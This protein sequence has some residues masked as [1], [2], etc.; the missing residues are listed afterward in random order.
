MEQTQLLEWEGEDDPGDPSNG[1]GDSGEPP[2]PVGRLHLLSNKYGPEKDFWIYPGE[3]VVGRLESCQ[4]CLPAPS[5]SKSHAVI[6]VP[7]PDGPH[8]LYDKGSLNRTR[9]QRLV[10][11]PEVRYS[12]Q[13]G[14]ALLFGDVRCQYFILPLGGAS[15]S[16]DESTEVP[17]TQARPDA[18]ALAIE[19]TPA[20]GR[21]TGSEGVLVHDSDKEE[22]G[23]D[24]MN[25][26]GKRNGSDPAVHDAS[27]GSFKV[28]SSMF[29]SPSVA[30]VPESDEENE[31]ASVRELPYPSVRLCFE[32]QEAEPGTLENGGVTPLNHKTHGVEPGDTEVTAK[33]QP[34]LEERMATTQESDPLIE[35][36]HL[37]SD[38]DVE[39]EEGTGGTSDL[40]TSRCLPETNKAPDVG[41]DT[42]VDEPVTGN[43]DN[44]KNHPRTIDVGSDTDVEET[45]EDPNVPQTHEPA[46]NGED[47][48]DA[49]EGTEK[50][51][52]VG[53]FEPGPQKEGGSKDIR[54][55]KEDS[56]VTTPQGHQLGED[57]DTDVE[58]DVGNSDGKAQK[59]LAKGD[60]DTD[61]DDASLKTKSPD[62]SQK[63]HEAGQDSDSDTVVDEE[64]SAGGALR[65]PAAVQDG[66]GDTDEEMSDLVL[67]HSDIAGTQSSHPVGG[68][69][70]DA[71]VE[72]TPLKGVVLLDKSYSG[73]GHKGTAVEAENPSVQLKGNYESTSGQLQSLVGNKPLENTV[74]VKDTA[75]SSQKPGLPIVS[76]DSDTDLEEEVENP[77]VGPKEGPQVAGVGPGEGSFLENS[78]AGPPESPV[79]GEAGDSDTDVEGNSPSRKELVAQGSH[80]DVE[81]AAVPSPGKPQEEQATQL[82]VP[83][84]ARMADGESAAP[85]TEVRVCQEPRKGDE[86]TATEGSEVPPADDDSDT[87]DDPDVA[88]QATQ[89]FLPPE[90]SSP[91]PGKAHRM[92]VADSSSCLEE[93]ATQPFIFQSPSL[94]TKVP[95][96]KACSSLLKE[97]NGDPYA[98]MLEAT[99]SFCQEPEPFSEE[100]TQAFAAPEEEDT[101]LVSRNPCEESRGDPL[102]Q[103]TT[104]ALPA[105]TARGQQAAG[106]SATTP[107]PSTLGSP[108][109]ELVSRTAT[110]V[111]VETPEKE[112]AETSRSRQIPSGPSGEPSMAL[113]E[114]PGNFRSEARVSVGTPEAGGAAGMFQP[115]S[116]EAGVHHESEERST[117]LAGA[118]R[119][120]AEQVSSCAKTELS[121]ASGRRRS[122]RLSSATS[123]SPASVPERRTL[124]RRGGL[125]ATEGSSETAVSL[126]LRRGLRKRG[127]ALPSMGEPEAK[128]VQLKKEEGG[129]GRGRQLREKA[130]AQGAG[131]GPLSEPSQD[132]TKGLQCRQQAERRGCRGRW[133]PYNQGAHKAGERPG[134]S[135]ACERTAAGN[136][137]NPGQ[138]AVKQH[139]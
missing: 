27:G 49:E 69:D 11:K 28:A 18:S 100:A 55:A 112:D 139:L 120:V 58:E 32:S 8:L 123:A 114:V 91:R 22:E 85:V 72:E 34:G 77:D 46:E 73:E 130:Q 132:L 102:E 95:L 61:V 54:P 137:P 2:V 109:S 76:M 82:W 126:S 128:K 81:E 108:S 48:T 47:D 21:R 135:R 86:D 40:P 1:S 118:S 94:S 57:S 31:E 96:G 87:D 138:Q 121:S 43:P 44:Q 10:L 74:V 50:P 4:I 110:E 14:D 33:T 25:G 105:S 107:E 75:A 3:N 20:P 12:L 29:S 66:D 134:S 53:G 24:G 106:L 84:G 30:V 131:S 133:Q 9:R 111:G 99:Q 129:G 59:V 103:G 115:L 89:C 51:S 64:A 35:N 104:P 13:D 26:A 15:E 125:G 23:E 52:I 136:S 93:E 80:A 5:V 41:S 97:D 119:D 36:F 90:T 60:S 67:E 39:D 113:Q 16:S 88:F 101:E 62:G 92:A 83:R 124:R 71:H 38:T 78:T 6:E 45:L 116:R 56:L 17:P 19:E 37:D 65:T 98:D 68:K 63:S 127:S 79:P 70:G 42:D 117:A 7:S 122:Q